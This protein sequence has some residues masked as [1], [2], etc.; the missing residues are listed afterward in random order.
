M[1]PYRNARNP[2][3]ISR[4][5]LWS[6]DFF[7]PFF[8]MMSVGRTL[9]VDIRD[10]G[11]HYLLEAELPGIDKQNL[12]LEVKEGVLTISANQE[13]ETRREEA[14]YLCSERRTGRVSR[15]FTLE[16]IDEAAISAEFAD[17][18]LR[19]KLPKQTKPEPESRRIDIH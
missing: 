17:G 4:N 5:P 7:R 19:M 3:T 8:E 16:N 9:P 2:L 1:I 10:E 15:S 11:P 12:S 13:Q 18:I 14:N 6:D